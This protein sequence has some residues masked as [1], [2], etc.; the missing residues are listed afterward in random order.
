MLVLNSDAEAGGLRVAAELLCVAARTAP[1]ACGKDFLVTAIVSG[2]EKAALQTRMRE[3]AARDG[4][5]FFAR[6]AGNLEQAP[7]V[8]LIGTRK[9]ALNIPACGYC[10]FADCQVMRAAG[11][12]CSFN[13]GDLGIAVG[14]AVSRAAD[15]RIDNRVLYTAGK[16][17]IEL[18]YLGPDV[19]IAYG[20]PLSA[21]GKN[22]F[23]DREPTCHAESA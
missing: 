22:P 23:F 17:A 4:V 8:V 10:G 18:G 3:I 1:K 7:F 16:A 2:E 5:S 14:S 6:D 15:L 19:P 13:A 20:I 12:T 11:G 21:K 9:E